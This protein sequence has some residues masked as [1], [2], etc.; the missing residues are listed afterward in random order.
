MTANTPWL[1]IPF[2]DPR[3]KDLKEFYN[4]RSV[5]LLILV[6]SEG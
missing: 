5:P 1:S 4:V 2:D 6:D 3:V